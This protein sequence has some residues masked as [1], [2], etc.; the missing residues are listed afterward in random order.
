M[1]VAAVPVDMEA[2]HALGGVFGPF[3]GTNGLQ[4]SSGN[5]LLRNRTGAVLFEASYSGDIP[6]P[7]AA[8]GAGHSLVLARPSFG[9]GD[10]R[11]WAAS[12]G[13]GGSPGRGELAGENPYR[14]VV[15]NEFLAHSIAPAFDF[16]ELFNESSQAAPSASPGPPPRVRP[17]VWSMPSISVLPGG[18]PWARIIWRREWL[19]PSS[20]AW[21]RAR[22]GFI[23]SCR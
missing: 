1:V 16:I 17:T 11:A 3:S 8:D 4:N 5:L 7:A 23:G 21:L 22:K 14:A 10:V 12:D 15:I 9:E 2:V 20:T 13:V 19:S 18:C 6:W